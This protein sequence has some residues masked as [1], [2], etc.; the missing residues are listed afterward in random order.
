MWMPSLECLISVLRFFGLTS[1]ALLGVL[2]TCHMGSEIYYNGLY[3][4]STDIF[5][6]VL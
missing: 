1:I 2:K 3:A 5:S 4:V 6:N